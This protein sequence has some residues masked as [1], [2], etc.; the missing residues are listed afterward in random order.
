LDLMRGGGE[1]HQGSANMAGRGG[2]R[3]QRGGS[4][5]RGQRGGRGSSRGGRASESGGRQSNQGGYIRRSTN[6]SDERPVCQVCFKKGHTAA[7]Y[8]HRFEEDFIPDEK[9]A[10]AATNPTTS[11]P[12][13]TRTP[14]PP[15]T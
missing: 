13:G 3:N 4:G 6:S 15:T 7:K 10:G 9:L 12:I 8:W 1:Q 11:T 14:A 5:G 2:R